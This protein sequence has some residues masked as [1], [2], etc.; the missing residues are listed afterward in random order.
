MK[1]IILVFVAAV[2]LSACQTI[3]PSFQFSPLSTEIA[4][5]ATQAGKEL[6]TN[7]WQPPIG[8]HLAK[9]DELEFLFRSRAYRFDSTDLPPGSVEFKADGTYARFFD[10]DLKPHIG[11]WSYSGNIL[12]MVFP[13]ANGGVSYVALVDHSGLI[14]LVR[15]TDTIDDE[16]NILSQAKLLEPESRQRFPAT[17]KAGSQDGVYMVLGR[18]ADP[19]CGYSSFNELIQIHENDIY[20]VKARGYDLRPLHLGKL[21]GNNTAEVTLPED[22]GQ[23]KPLDVSFG[24]KGFATALW[25]R[26]Q[27]DMNLTIRKLE[28]ALPY[29][30]SFEENIKRGMPVFPPPSKNTPDE[31]RTALMNKVLIHNWSKKPG[32]LVVRYFNAIGPSTFVEQGKEY[33]FTWKVDYL[34]KE[35]SG[36]ST[37]LILDNNSWGMIAR[38]RPEPGVFTTSLIEGGETYLN[39]WVSVIGDCWPAKNSKVSAPEGVRACQSSE[40]KTLMKRFVLAKQVYSSKAVE[41]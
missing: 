41:R 4:S 6:R 37:S 25:H 30:V 24:R 35:L 11:N 18:P 2:S 34:D 23:A 28:K 36:R 29:D 16:I 20:L 19:T 15:N 38:L 13:K 21:T 33:T 9:P 14:V 5:S 40:E 32:A 39:W 26:K 12:K 7:H 17:V 10:S 3:T 8:W 27:C 22:D 1:F 31:V